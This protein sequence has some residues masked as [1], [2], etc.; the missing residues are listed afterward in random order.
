MS[1]SR[2]RRA[3]RHA[4]SP[5]AGRWGALL[6]AAAAMS[7]GG[8]A[9][10]HECPIVTV[11]GCSRPPTTT[12]TIASSETTTTTTAA[13]T[14]TTTTVAPTSTTVITEP[15]A[16][17]R[18]FDLVNGERTSAGLAPLAYRADIADIAQAWSG[19]LARRGVLA[20]ND[21]YFT[22]ETRKRLGAKAL[23]ENVAR[24]GDVDAAHRALMA[25]SGHRANILD[26]RFR[27]LGVGAVLRDGTWWFTQ[28]F[29]E[30]VAAPPSAPTPG[31]LPRSMPASTSAAPRQAMPPRPGQPAIEAAAAGP[32][33][34]VVLDATAPAPGTTTLTRPDERHST[35]GWVA[36]AAAALAMPL[37]I[38]TAEA[39]RRAIH[40]LRSNRTPATAERQTLR[41]ALS[42]I[43]GQAR[44]R[45]SNV[46]DHDEVRVEEERVA[47]TVGP[48][49]EIMH[50]T[51]RHHLSVIDAWISTLDDRWSVLTESDRL[52][53]V[54][55]IR[56]NTRE[57]LEPQPLA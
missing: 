54:Q 33:E 22:R 6:L 10:A 3:G 48:E 47:D 27:V 52:I 28:D 4:A 31:E 36:I 46:P 9:D 53:A 37:L 8:E 40:V 50:E 39:R 15:A 35:S 43:T 20:H 38:L 56:R 23:G 21:D 51:L 42:V 19:E 55:V 49:I 45:P 44:R 26:G 24:A 30:P 13:P 7:I 11:P 29:L 25:S 17:A 16:A 34:V 12:T 57:A 14:P 41:H 2:V 32:T 5:R 1:G 18:L